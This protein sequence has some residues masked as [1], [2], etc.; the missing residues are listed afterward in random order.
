MTIVVV[1]SNSYGPNSYHMTFRPDRQT[2][3][4]WGCHSNHVTSFLAFVQLCCTVSSFDHCPPSRPASSLQK[5][6]SKSGSKQLPGSFLKPSFLSRSPRPVSP[7]SQPKTQ[8]KMSRREGMIAMLKK[9]QFK[10]IADC[11][12][13]SLS[14]WPMGWDD[15]WWCGRGSWLRL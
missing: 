9:P 7:T 10:E 12:N 4:W 13:R 14:W 2:V 11:L 6:S 5:G 15:G 8:Q 3:T 1:V